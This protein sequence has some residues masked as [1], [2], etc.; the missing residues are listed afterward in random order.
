[1]KR[2]EP[3]E[4]AGLFKLSA[5]YKEITCQTPRHSYKEIKYTKALKTHTTLHNIRQIGR[6]AK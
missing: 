2:R 6:C 3:E 1:M 4:E 5:P